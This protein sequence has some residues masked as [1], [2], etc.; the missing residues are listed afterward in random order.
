MIFS[1]I[2]QRYIFREFFKIFSLFL[3]GFYLLYVVIDYSI[4]MQDFLH[5]ANLSLRKIIEYYLLQFI[6]RTDIL[7][8]LAVLLGAIKVLCQMNNHR[9]LVA[10][11]SGGLKQKALLQPL[12]FVGFLCTLCNL[13]INE[14]AVPYSL[15]YID[16]FYDA[17]LSRSYRGTRSQPLH[18]MHLDD[19]SKLVYQYYDAS[20]EAFF[21]VFWIKSSNDIWRMKYL[22]ADPEEP[23]GQF[24]DHLIRSEGGLK[25]TESHESYLFFD[26]S[27]SEQMPKK[28]FIPF[29]NRSIRELW[30]LYRHDPLLSSYDR[31]SI[32]TQGLYKIMMPLLSF[33]VILAVAPSCLLPR[34]NIPQFFIYA[35]G[36]FGFCGFVALMDA[37]VILGENDTLSPYVAILSPFIALVGI[38]GWRFAKSP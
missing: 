23:M 10:F 17:H 36:I 6:K 21:D 31:Q 15:N 25:K 4:H 35:F 12:F 30:N 24:V 26:L 11:Q 9:E 20:R 14:F 3:F 16:K 37:A 28:G 34:P 33:I 18:V 19:H 29:E 8:P 22:K 32:L 27:W 7:F 2:W 38:V 5:S 1:K 13:G